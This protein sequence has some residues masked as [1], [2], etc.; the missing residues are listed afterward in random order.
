MSHNEFF[1]NL[2]FGSLCLGFFWGEILGTGLQLSQRL[3]LSATS[4]DCILL[5]LVFEPKSID[6]RLKAKSIQRVRSVVFRF[7]LQ[8]R[9]G[10]P[11]LKVAGDIVL[12]F[13]TVQRVLEVTRPVLI[14]TTVV[15]FNQ[16][17]G[18]P[19]ASR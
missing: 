3:T 13:T 9:E 15:R 6:N 14:P 18:S 4:S 11:F 19:I 12:A 10:N 7:D 16:R 1:P 8:S 5:M 2:A 17:P